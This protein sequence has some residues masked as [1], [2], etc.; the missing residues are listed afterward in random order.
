MVRSGGTDEAWAIPLFRAGMK[1]EL[2]D[3]QNAAACLFHAEVHL[4]LG[5]GKD[6]HLHNLG[7][8]PVRVIAIVIVLNAQQHEKSLINAPNHFFINGDAGVTGALNQGAHT[9]PREASSVG[10]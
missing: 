6:S 9:T 10:K 7:R 3:D 1:G 5:I 2:T 4:A 8:K